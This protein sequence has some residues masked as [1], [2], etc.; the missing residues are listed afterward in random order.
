[1]ANSILYNTGDLNTLIEGNGGQIVNSSAL[2]VTGLDQI[3]ITLTNTLVNPTDVAQNLSGLAFYFTTPLSGTAELTSS[4]GLERNVIKGG[5][6]KNP[7]NIYN[8]GSMV[9]T[10]WE[11]GAIT[12]GLDLNVLGTPVGPAHTIIGSPDLSNIYSNA[13]G[14]IVGNGPHNLFLAGPVTFS[15]DAPGMTAHTNIDQ[16]WFAYGTA[17]MTPPPP[18]HVPEPASLL[19]LG[20]G[21][22]GV[23]GVRRFRK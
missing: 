22:F 21:L 19:L 7:I 12:G 15:I 3:T 17:A 11:L 8:D 5:T 1:M 2:F 14:S 10:G 13:N 16:V 18:P 4:A 23:A 20:L 6:K 9:A